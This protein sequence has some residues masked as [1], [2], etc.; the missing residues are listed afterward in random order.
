MPTKPENEVL[1]ALVNRRYPVSDELW[2]DFW[3][4]LGTREL[5]PGEA[6]AFVCVLST[7]MPDG[8]SIAA[9]LRS[10]R[11]RNPQPDPPAQTTVNIVGTGGGPSTFNLS[12][13]SAFVAASMGARVIKTGSRAYASKTGS[14][15]LL[16]RLGLER[17]DVVGASLGG[18]LAAEL[19]VHSP[20]R[21]R[22][23]VLVDAIGLDLP[24][25]PFADLFAM[26]RDETVATLFHDP[27]VGEH[28]FPPDPGIDVL[29]QEYKDRTAFARVAWSPF[30]CDP[31][32]ERRLRRIAAPTLVLWGA[33]DLVASVDHGRRYA[34]LIPQARLLVLERCGHAAL[35]EQTER[36]VAAIAEFLV[37][38]AP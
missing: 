4:R 29:V 16:D 24:A 13:A 32:L 17:A 21:V 9:L 11:A 8:A 10:L 26:T 37:G 7:R 15:D 23:L 33:D 18:W 38:G 1:E 12:T 36:A 31:K 34:A 22:R 28:A 35:V 14:I 20:H 27:A 5:R 19:A 3:D 2:G 25:H 30:M 6:L